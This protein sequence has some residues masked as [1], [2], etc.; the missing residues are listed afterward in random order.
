MIQKLFSTKGRINR[1]TYTISYGIGMALGIILALLSNKYY[2]NDIAYKDIPILLL[3]VSP[4][5]YANYCL[6]VKRLHDMDMPSSNYWQL[7]R[8]WT[9]QYRLFLEEGTYGKNQY[10]Y[11]QSPPNSKRVSSNS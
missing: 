8:S 5:L 7:N 3:C 9:L 2:P 10:G 6:T 1:K 11:P 4:F